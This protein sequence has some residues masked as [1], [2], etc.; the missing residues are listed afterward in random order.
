M[1]K[2]HGI[3]SSFQAALQNFAQK[4]KASDKM[5]AADEKLQVSAK[6]GSAWA[7]LNS[8]F[9]KAMDTP[10]GHRLR[11]FYG[12]LCLRLHPT[13]NLHICTDTLIVD[14]N[15]QVMDVHNEARHLANLRGGKST[16]QPVPGQEGRTQCNCGKQRLSR[17]YS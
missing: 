15:K 3:S 17:I 5:V 6:A 7:G 4:F 1:D 10:T 9:E 13:S 11:K 8:Y 14:G 16:A 12:K 2:K